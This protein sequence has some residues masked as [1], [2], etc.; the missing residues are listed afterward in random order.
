MRVL[1]APIK[2]N[3]ADAFFCGALCGNRVC[4][5]SDVSGT[6]RQGLHRIISVELR[7]RELPDI[8]VETRSNCS[9]RCSALCEVDVGSEMRILSATTVQLRE[10][11]PYYLFPMISSEPGT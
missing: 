11:G 3:F 8:F 2:G 5:R 1:Q 10:G 7:G 4:R 6:L 9:P